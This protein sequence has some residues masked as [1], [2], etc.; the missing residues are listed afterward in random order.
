VVALTPSDYRPSPHTGGER[1]Q[2]VAGV[3]RVGGRLVTLIDLAE[4]LREQTM[5]A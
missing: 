4:M 5:L 3:A 2:F 1:D